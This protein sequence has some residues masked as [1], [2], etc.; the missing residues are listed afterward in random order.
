VLYRHHINS[1]VL[2]EFIPVEIIKCEF[3]SFRSGVLEA[4]F[5]FLGCGAAS[6]GDWCPTFGD[7]LVVSSSRAEMSVKNF[8][9]LDEETSTWQFLI[10]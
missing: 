8:W 9:T 1:H 4:S 6:L 5:L 2:N 7:D 3:L 10:F